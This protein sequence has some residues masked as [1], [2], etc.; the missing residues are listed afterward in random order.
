MDR[1]CYGPLRRPYFKNSAG[2]TYFK[3]FFEKN[4]LSDRRCFVVWFRPIYAGLPPSPQ[5]LVE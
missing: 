2:K 4:S 3:I 1:A 5:P